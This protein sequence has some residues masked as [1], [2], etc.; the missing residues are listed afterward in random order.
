M[1]I[2]GSMFGGLLAA[3]A[4]ITVP[5]AGARESVTTGAILLGFA[6][7][8]G[9]M[10]LLSERLSD[11][12]QRWAA[13]PA[14][15]MAL[16]GA[17]L[18]V[19]AP[20]AAAVSTV[21]W[22]WPPLLLAL[23]VWMTT[24]A[25]RRSAD[26]PRRAVLYPVFG[27]LALAGIG[28]AYETLRTS[29]DSALADGRGLVD[30][31]GHRLHI[32]CMGSGSPTVVLEPGLGESATTMA[33]W[34]V[35]SVART[36]RI[37]V[38]DQ[39]GHGRS[40]GAPGNRADAAR[41]LHVVLQRSQIR[42][43]YVVAGHSLGGIFALSY[44]QRYPREV[45]GIVLLD[46]MHPKQTTV[47]DHADPL[48][49]LVPT[50]SRTGLAGLLFDKKD[51]EPGAQMRQLAR[52]VEAMPAEMNQAAKLT[53]LGDRPLA[54]IT[55]DLGNQPGWRANQAR[56][57]ALSSTSTHRIIAGSTH[58]SLIDD[59][60]DAMHSGDAIRD[61]VRAVRESRRPAAIHRGDTPTAPGA[62]LPAS[63]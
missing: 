8:W 58:Q 5:F 39:A 19:L 1:I 60:A 33:H 4:L 53:S 6:F 24:Q 40:Q 15:A 52:D 10:A 37:C 13:V 23:V 35:P 49:S 17:G 34:I 41:D 36:T 43:P 2:T 9:L 55:A 14:T 21:G 46:S 27:V 44:A 22:V 11:R 7:G 47:F 57:A 61:V 32:Q 48:I 45:A 20:G 63:R 26:W 30:V 42:G 18:V 56:L 50:L 51:G 59:R 12:P 28:G 3:A 38:Y 31:G 16:S 25:R 62:R 54:V 29:T